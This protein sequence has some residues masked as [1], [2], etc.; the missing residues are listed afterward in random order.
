MADRIAETVGRGRPRRF[1][2]E[3]ERRL[4]L[5]AAMDLLRT[6]GYRDFGVADILESAQLST[7]SFYRHFESKEALHVALLRREIASVVRHLTRVV[8]AA[9]DPVAGIEA[10]IDAFLDTFFDPRLASRSAAF[11]TPAT[12]SISPLTEEMGRVRRELCQPLAAALRRGHASGALRSPDPDQD[13]RSVYGLLTAAA[14]PADGHD[15]AT[16]RAQVIRF[17]WPALGLPIER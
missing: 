6:R 13:A 1:D 8:A 12:M 5:D 15:R 7:R 17:A 2:D 4:L 14:V 16:A 10:W 3:T 9:D 11:T